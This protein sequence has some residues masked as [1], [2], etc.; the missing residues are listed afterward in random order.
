MYKCRVL[1]GHCCEDLHNQ[2]LVQFATSVL[3]K[4]HLRCGMEAINMWVVP[5]SV[6]SGDKFY[7]VSCFLILF[8]Y[9]LSQA[10]SFAE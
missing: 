2:R 8:E 6:H 1:Q 5:F 4:G 3:R 10:L 7:P 9:N